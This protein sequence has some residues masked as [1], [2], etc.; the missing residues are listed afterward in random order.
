MRKCPSRSLSSSNGWVQWPP[1]TVAHDCIPKHQ[2]ST[3]KRKIN[4]QRSFL[5]CLRAVLMRTFYYGY[6]APTF[7]EV[8]I[9]FSWTHE[10]KNNVLCDNQILHISSQLWM[11]TAISE[12]WSAHEKVFIWQ[13]FHYFIILL[14][15]NIMVGT[16]M[17][18]QYQLFP[19]IIQSSQCWIQFETICYHIY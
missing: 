14:E 3:S 17:K 7:Q 8:T 19:K 18:I 5:F 1:R 13:L 12:H 4:R 6:F 2:A 16:A 11:E 10:I 9:L 15:R